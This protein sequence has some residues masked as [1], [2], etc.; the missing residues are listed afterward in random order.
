[1]LYLQFTLVPSCMQVHPIFMLSVAD[2]LLSFLWIIG[3]GAWLRRLSDRVWCYAISL[4]TIVS[5]RDTNHGPDCSDF[6]LSIFV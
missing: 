1:M 5:L 2:L 4:P 6:K 3:G